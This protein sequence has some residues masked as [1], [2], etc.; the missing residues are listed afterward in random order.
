[1]RIILASQSP[2]RVRA[3][4]RLNIKFDVI[5]SNF[6]EESIKEKNPLKLVEK[7]ALEK[8]RLVARKYPNSLVIGADTL[9][10]LDEEILGKPKDILDARRILRQASGKTI[11]DFNGL[12][13]VYKGKEKSIG[14]IGTAVMR[15]YNNAEI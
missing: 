13:V 4:K 7:L 1:M 14:L 2:R 15:R 11:N 12:A 5:A 6:A 8:A 10:K 3:M 9:I